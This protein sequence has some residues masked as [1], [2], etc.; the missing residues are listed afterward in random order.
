MIPGMKHLAVLVALSVMAIGMTGGAIARDEPATW[1]GAI[2]APPITL[3]SPMTE[4]PLVRTGAR[5]L[6]LPKPAGPV[7]D[8]VVIP[9]NEGGGT[10][11]LLT[12]WKD[13]WLVGTN[14]GEW[15]GSLYVVRPAG[16]TRVARGNVI[17]GF[18]WGGRLHILSGLNHMASNVGE[19]WVVDPASMALTRRTPLP[20]MPE[21][22]LVA[23][24]GRVIV[25]TALG[26][27]ML[28]RDGSVRPAT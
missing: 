28:A 3:E 18:R 25:R 11:T 20:A 16:R 8:A 4:I 19:I 9:Q 2:T 5:R 27:V 24:G 10:V 21:E 15:V 6:I 22:V 1:R 26:D 7:P 13:G 23:S 17:G 14:A 12:P